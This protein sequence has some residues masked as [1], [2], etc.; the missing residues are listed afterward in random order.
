MQ[1]WLMAKSTQLWPENNFKL[2]S[3]FNE[4]FVYKSEGQLPN[5]KKT[6]QNKKS[7]V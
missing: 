5:K 1:R 6:K 3:T 4:A 2:R 7:R